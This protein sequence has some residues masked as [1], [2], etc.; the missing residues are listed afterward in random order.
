[1]DVTL[2]F[3][4]PFCAKKWSRFE[5]KFHND[6]RIGPSLENG[7]CNCFFLPVKHLEEGFFL[8]I[9]EEGDIL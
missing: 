5:K 9:E 7:T 8:V 2:F 1:M 3:D 6:P 4:N